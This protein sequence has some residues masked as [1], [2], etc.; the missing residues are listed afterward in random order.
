M[1]ERC[2]DGLRDLL[3]KCRNDNDDDN[4]GYDDGRDR[5]RLSYWDLH[6]FHIYLSF[7]DSPA[8]YMT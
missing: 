1:R 5:I 8:T 6:T 4:A 7:L 2:H 3:E